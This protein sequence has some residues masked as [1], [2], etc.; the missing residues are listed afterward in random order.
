MPLWSPNHLAINYFQAFRL[1]D[2]FIFCKAQRVS[3]IASTAHF[4]CQTHIDDHPLPPPQ[5]AESI[6]FTKVIYTLCFRHSSSLS[7][8]NSDYFRNNLDPLIAFDVIKHI[9]SFFNNPTLAFKFFQVTRE[10]LNLVHSFGTYNVLLRSLCQMRLHDAA[11]LVYGYVKIDGYLP[12]MSI[13]GFLVSSFANVGKF[14]IAKE[15]LIDQAEVSNG[16]VGIISSYVYND[17]LN[18]LVKQNRVEEAVGFFR[19]HIL[20]LRSFCP[21]TWSFNIVIRG[22][23]RVGDVNKA[24]KFLDDMRR[25]GCMPDLVTC[26]TLTNGLCRIGNVDRGHAFLREVKSQFGLSPDVVTYTS[27]ISGYC[28][29]GKMEEALNLFDDM[30]SFGIKPSLV[31][32]NILIDGFGKTSDIVSALNIYE[33]LL[34]TGCCPDVITF[35]SLIDGYCRT[36][37]VD[38]GL[39]LWGEINA[40]NLSP[41]AYTFSVLINALCKENRLNEARDLLRLLR[42]RTD[43]VPHPF[44][45]N[46]VID[47]FCKSGNV[48]EANVIVTEMEEKRCSPDK[49]TFTILILGHCMKG[50]MFDAIS[51]F[52]KMLSV[53]CAPDNITVNCLISCLLKAGM[54]NEAFRIKQTTSEDLN[55]GMSSLSRTI[56]FRANV[57]VPVAA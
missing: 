38:Q 50:R 10:N 41:N 6:W 8:F 39:K 34:T 57:D 25:F 28:K 1:F 7:I 56:P 15:L 5:T 2:S 42:W 43:I 44:I 19:D 26:N 24:F 20:R 53:G 3:K 47:G 14:D 22:L 12:E 16:E 54:P 32:F 55:W 49:L 40:R 52:N 11:K 37:Q 45:Y 21:D 17:L 31:T 9:N 48:D 35:T 46:P 51:I 13:L 27:V 30:F 33:R 23:C 18:L 29:L 36:G 4:H